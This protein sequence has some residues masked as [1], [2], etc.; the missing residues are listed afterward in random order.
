MQGFGLQT[1]SLD[2][3][4]YLIEQDFFISIEYVLILLAVATL[5]LCQG[6]ARHSM[7]T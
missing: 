5:D 2:V 4:G 3:D 6:A 7:P 1:E